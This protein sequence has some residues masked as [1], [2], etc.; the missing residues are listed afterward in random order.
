MIEFV[1]DLLLHLSIIM[2]LGF[3]YNFLYAQRRYAYRLQL[4][5][6]AVI[7]ALF[8]TMVFPVEF[9]NG[10]V[11]DM[12]LIPFFISFFYIGISQSLL[13][14]GFMLWIQIMLSVEGVFII[15]INYFFMFLLFTGL[16]SRYERTTLLKKILIAGSTYTLITLTRI[17]SL[18]Q[19]NL[20]DQ[21]PFLL[22]FSLVS[23][24]ALGA[25]IYII[26]ITNFQLK[27]ISE[28]QKAEKMSAISQLSASIAH[29]IRNPMT[30]IKGF[31]QVLKHDKNL[32][33]DQKLYINVSL[34]E[35]ERTQTIINNFLS[36]AKPNIKQDDVIELSSLLEE[37]AEFM[38]PF[39]LYSNIE[40]HLTMEESLSAKGDAN[41]LRQVFI[42]II[43]NGIEAMPDGGIFYIKATRSGEFTRIEFKDEG[44]G[45]SHK[46]FSRLG[47]PYFST[48]EKGTGLGLMICYDIIKR[49]NGEITV[50][51]IEKVGTTFTIRLPV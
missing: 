2:F 38:R 47:Q 37:I 11:F 36:M 48:K 35:L 39:A 15:I 10:L 34:H 22:V 32:T 5:V 44:V 19:S 17:S 26:E 41:E 45:I 43:K 21:I 25:T 40:I 24:L 12:K 30:T 9:K 28:L 3:I 27:T 50:D 29:E 1:K 31:M 42:N 14:I 49:M 51:S 13:L 23:F 16:K 18:V 7:I 4:F 20:T 46:L 8:I 6:C 33:E